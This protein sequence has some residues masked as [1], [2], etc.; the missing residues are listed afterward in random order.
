MDKIANGEAGDVEEVHPQE[1]PTYKQ[2]FSALRWRSLPHACLHALLSGCMFTVKCL[3]Y[4][5][6]AHVTKMLRCQQTCQQLLDN[7]ATLQQLQ[8]HAHRFS[9]DLLPLVCQALGAVIA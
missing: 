9:I 1:D 7:S 2:N 3:K 8:Y 6:H 4:L 5:L